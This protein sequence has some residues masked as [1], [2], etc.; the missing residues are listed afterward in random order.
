MGSR[1]SSF[2]I[3]VSSIT[4]N[5]TVLPPTAPSSRFSVSQLTSKTPTTVKATPDSAT[6]LKSSPRTSHPRMAARKG[7]KESIK[8]TRR[9]PSSCKPC[10]QV[11]SPMRIPAVDDKQRYP[12]AL[13]DDM[14]LKN[15][16]VDVRLTTKTNPTAARL[17]LKRFSA[18]AL[19]LQ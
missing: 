1:V 15:S 17:H 9:A 12:T 8:I 19:P 16:W 13:A 14:L 6:S 10:N 5:S 4:D 3:S 11:Q 2:T 18:K 7:L